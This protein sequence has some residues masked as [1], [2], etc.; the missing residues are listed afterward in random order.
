M[1]DSAM[2]A[3]HSQAMATKRSQETTPR[4]ITSVNLPFQASVNL[5]LA[6]NKK[7]E[8]DCFNST[9]LDSM[10]KSFGDKSK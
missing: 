8:L 4:V 3:K 1:F 2:V 9:A 10:L 5:K 6:K 7:R